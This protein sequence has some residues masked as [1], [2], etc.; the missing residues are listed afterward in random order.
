MN[1]DQETR[2]KQVVEFC[3]QEFRKL[4]VE[5]FIISDLDPEGENAGGGYIIGDAKQIHTFAVFLMS[6]VAV[7]HMAQSMGRELS[8]EREL[9][10]GEAFFNIISESM[11]IAL[12]ESF[13]VFEKMEGKIQ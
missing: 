10:L 9:Q 11:K 5:S 12:S 6:K 3:A 1:T 4:G 13:K 2:F 7:M 8:A